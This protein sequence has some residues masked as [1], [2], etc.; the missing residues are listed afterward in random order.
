M[1]MKCDDDD[2]FHLFIRINKVIR[3]FYIRDYKHIYL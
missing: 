2:D 1:Y 3:L